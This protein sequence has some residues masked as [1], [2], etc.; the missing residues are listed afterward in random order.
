MSCAES[1]AESVPENS[2]KDQKSEFV[3]LHGC[4]EFVVNIYIP[5]PPAKQFPTVVLEYGIHV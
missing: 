3:H 5:P 2:S 4:M 1:L